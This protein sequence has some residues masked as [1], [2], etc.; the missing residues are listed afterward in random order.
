[1]IGKWC[2]L[3][4]ATQYDIDFSQLHVITNDVGYFYNIVSDKEFGF[5]VRCIKD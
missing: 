3:C 2:Y 1:M 4:S 5:S